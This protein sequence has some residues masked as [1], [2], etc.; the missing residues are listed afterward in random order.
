MRLVEEIKYSLE[1]EIKKVKI[2][3]FL[4]SQDMKIVY[5]YYK[6]KKM[7]NK[8]FHIHSST[9]SILSILI[10]IA[11]DRGKIGSIQDSIAEYLHN[12]PEDKRQITIEHLLTMTPGWEWGEF[13]EWGGRPFPMINSKEWVKFVLERDME[14]SPGIKMTY[15]SGASHLLSAI[16]QEAIGETAAS[17]AEKYLFNPLNITKYRWHEDSKGRTI[18]GFG[19]CLKAEDM[20]KIGHVMLNRGVWDNKQIVSEKWVHESTMARFHTYDHIGSYGYHWWVLVDENN[21]PYHPNIFFSMGYGG[22]YIIANPVKN[23]VVVVTSEL[24]HDTFFLL[25][26]FRKYFL[27]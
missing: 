7:V 15:N 12:V 22:Q 1:K 5:Q 11:I 6:N 17:Y 9:K 25:R 24:Y 21:K 18:G 14:I 3:S 19:L 16:L 20:L 10:G 8:L 2:S 4:I 13:G 23:L 26:L 27:R